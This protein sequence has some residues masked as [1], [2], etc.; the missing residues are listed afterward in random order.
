M[1]HA[2]VSILLKYSEK[3]IYSWNKCSDKLCILC[4][5]LGN[6]LKTVPKQTWEI[7]SFLDDKPETLVFAKECKFNLPNG[8]YM[9]W[10]TK[11]TGLFANYQRI[12]HKI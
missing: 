8:W 12:S 2:C 3:M 4:S 1:T 9:H 5:E 6:R 11:T 7:E 10:I